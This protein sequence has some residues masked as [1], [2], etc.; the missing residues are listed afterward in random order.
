MKEVGVIMNDLSQIAPLHINQH[1]H[2]NT[3]AWYIT[4]VHHGGDK[5]RIIMI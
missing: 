2:F 1:V 3:H 4:E 5:M